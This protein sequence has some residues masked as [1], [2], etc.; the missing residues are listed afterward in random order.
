MSFQQKFDRK[1][2]ENQEDQITVKPSKIIKANVN[3]LH[4]KK[5]AKELMRN[6]KK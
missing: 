5:K 2:P 6:Q 3:V 4:Y 1:N